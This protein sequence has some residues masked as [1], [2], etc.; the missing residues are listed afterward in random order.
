VS[1]EDRIPEVTLY[2]PMHMWP[3]LRMLMLKRGYRVEPLGTDPTV[4]DQYELS[5]RQGAAE[6]AN[7][8]P[9]L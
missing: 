6:Q 8:G 9:W 4:A 2:V 3:A 1:G 7:P 5:W